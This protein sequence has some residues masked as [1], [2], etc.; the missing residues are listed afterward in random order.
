MAETVQ[1]LIEHGHTFEQITSYPPHLLGRMI[2]A[3]HRIDSQRNKEG[4][5]MSWV[6]NNLSYEGLQK[7]INAKDRIG[8]KKSKEITPAQSRK[9]AIGLSKALKM[10]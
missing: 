5:L 8:N 6:A 1:F 10:G 3:V 9:A 2:V 4:A 7:F